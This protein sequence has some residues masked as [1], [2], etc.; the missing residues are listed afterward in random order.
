MS[1]DPT[2]DCT[3]WYTQEYY[4]TTSSAG[5]QTRVGA[6]KFPGCVAGPSGII[7]GYVKSTAGGTPIAGATVQ[8]RARPSRR[9][10]TPLASTPSPSP[11]GTYDVTASKFGYSPATATGQAVTDGGT[12]T[13]A[14]LLLTPVGTYAVDGFVT[15]AVHNWPLWARVEVRQAGTLINTLYTSPWNGYYEIPDL[16]NGFTYDFTVHSM[17]QGYQDEVRSVT[18]ASGDQIQNFTLLAASGNPAYACYLQGGINENFDGAFPPLGWTVVERR[19]RCQQHLEAERHV[20]A[21]QP[22]G[23]HRHRGRCRLGQG[24]QRLRAVQHRA[25]VSAR[26]RCRRPRA[27]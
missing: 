19:L 6:F 17:Y 21:G 25:L 16:P 12:T 27:T 14:D 26:S 1:V 4:A 7:Q 8:H 18:L 9:P 13:V 3:F 2:D 24:W 22:D 15:A 23:W 20:G 11:V 5:W 10:R